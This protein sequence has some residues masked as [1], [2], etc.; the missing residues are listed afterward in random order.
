MSLSIPPQRVGPYLRALRAGLHALALDADFSPLPTLDAHLAALDP[1]VSGPLLAP[2]SVDPHTGLPDATWMARAVAER[3]ALIERPPPS[4]ERVARIAAHDPELAAR[5]EGRI[6]LARHL[7]HHELLPELSVSARVV[8]RAGPVLER[9]RAVVDRRL[10]GAG[11]V[12]LRVDVGP[13][14]APGEVVAR[15]Q[16]DGTAV[17]QPGVAE[18]LVRHIRTP[19]LLLNAVLQDVLEAPVLRVSVGF[20]GPFWFP[21]GPTDARAPAWAEGALVLHAV[22][23]VV[24]DTVRTSGCAD[25]FYD[26]G[27]QSSQAGPSPE[28][29][30]GTWRDRMLAVSPP[31]LDAARAWVA[32]RGG[33]GGVVAIQPR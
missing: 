13:T 23:G 30:P 29:A 3:A 9:V 31:V 27:A 24:G 8:R 11:L 6:G 7:R 28:A 25:P 4:P 18:L 12:R 14:G 17:L 33:S 32:E 19:L 22:R 15:V 2:A 20:V 10:P 26:V 21:G 5:L 1:A 16:P